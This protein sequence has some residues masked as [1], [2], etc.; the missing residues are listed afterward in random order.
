MNEERRLGELPEVRASSFKVALIVTGTIIGL[1]VL[2]CGGVAAYVAGTGPSEESAEVPAPPTP[3]QSESPLD[4]ATIATIDLPPDFAQTPI[5]TRD[6]LSP[7]KSIRFSRKTDGG[8]ELL[9]ARVDL[10][11]LPAQITPEKLREMVLK[12]LETAGELSRTF[13]R[14]ADSMDTERELSVLGQRTPVEITYGTLGPGDK[15]VVKVAGLFSRQKAGIAIVY[16]IP[17]DEYEEQAIVKMFES[18]QLA[19]GN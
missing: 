18:I 17:R 16:I 7:M 8:A 10:S 2:V 13:H 14:A 6:P 15:P 12:R 4:P 3:L 1:S 19:S 11:S 9:M 5:A